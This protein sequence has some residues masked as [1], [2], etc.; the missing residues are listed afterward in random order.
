MRIGSEV[1]GYRVEA[2]LGRG[3]AG[4]SLRA[5]VPGSGRR[6]MLKVLGLEAPGGETLRARAERVASPLGRAAHETIQPLEACLVEGDRLVIVREWID[7]EDLCGLIAGGRLRALSATVEL[8]SQVAEGLDAARWGYGLAH[9]N[10]KP[11]NVLMTRGSD[12]RVRDD[13]R[14]LAWSVRLVDFALSEQLAL[15]SAPGGRTAAEFLAPEQIGGQE[16]TARS[17]QYALACIAFACLTGRPPFTGDAGAIAEAHVRATPPSVRELRPE[18]PAAI[19]DALSPALARRPED[20]YPTCRALAAALRAARDGTAS[21]RP[22][23]TSP[24]AAGEPA[25]PVAAEPEPGSATSGETARPTPRSRRRRLFMPAAAVAVVALAIA[26]P[27]L[28]LS[29]EDEQQAANDTVAPAA[30]ASVGAAPEPA[31]EGDGSELSADATTSASS[32]SLAARSWA[33]VGDKSVL[34]GPGDEQMLSAVAAGAGLIAVGRDGTPGD[35]DAAVWTSGDGRTWS[36]VAHDEASFANAQMHDATGTG[37]LL[38]AVGSRESDAAVWTS[39]DGV[40][41]TPVEDAAAELAGEGDQAMLSVTEGGPGLVAVGIDGSNAAA[42]AS[43]DG[44][45]WIRIP[46]DEA[47]FG[48]PGSQV[49]VSVTRGGPGLVAVG[50]DGFDA[51]AWASVDG[52]TWSR[53][54]VAGAGASGATMRG[55]AAGSE[56]LVAVGQDSVNAAAWTS[57]DGLR[58]TRVPEEQR[59]FRGGGLRLMRDVVAAGPGFVSVGQT[60]SD[61]TVW[62]SADGRS[63]SRAFDDDSSPGGGM[64]AVTATEKGLVGVGSA[65][66]DAAVWTSI[67]GST[68]SRASETAEVFGGEAPQAMLDV[69]AGGPGFVAVGTDAFEAAVWTSADGLSWSRRRDGSRAPGAEAMLSVTQ[70]GPGLVAVGF[71]GGNGLDAAVWTSLDGLEWERAAHDPVL[72][73]PGDQVMV[74]VIAGGPG[75]VAA[76]RDGLDAAVWTSTDGIRWSRARSRGSDFEGARIHGLSQGGPGLVAVGSDGTEPVV[77]TSVDGLSWARAGDGVTAV[78]GPTIRGPG[79]M[80]D[81]TQGGPGLVAVGGDLLDAAVWT[82][83]DGVLWSRAPR[84]GSLSGGPDRLTMRSATTTGD[85]LVAVGTDGTSAAVWTSSDGLVWSRV[86]SA[87]SAFGG[88]GRADMQGVATAEGR[89]WRWDRQAIPTWMRR[90]GRLWAEKRAAVSV[91]AEFRPMST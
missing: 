50:Q 4:L 28:L 48:G 13:D 68:W 52:L 82:S 9:G 66:L 15:R 89:S 11:S 24:R 21:P 22:A 87:D 43:V 1:S 53:A 41:W 2:I 73:G 63:W 57:Q 58:W 54:T 67:D 79:L 6:V 5:L 86:P 80:L 76:G 61:A 84:A 65:R 51:A 7:A 83:T 35:R 14:E 20:R 39:T 10:L 77:W 44:S 47:L 25:E 30:P 3:P 36:R 46:H 12:G 69:T 59:A 72:V 71:D 64:F 29:S 55:V 19:N 56:G 81:V 8:V 18:L 33:R 45:T 23:P 17:D 90:S 91:S 42:W 60:G 27:L 74:A 38:V 88:S 32:V 85:G 26:L 70:G 78:I 31:P 62:T 16:P 34:G 37:A 40:A 49:I 75:V